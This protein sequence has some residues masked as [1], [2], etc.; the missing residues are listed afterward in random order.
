MGALA[1][2]GNYAQ[3][4]IIGGSTTVGDH[5]LAHVNAGEMILNQREQTRLWHMVNG[6]GIDSNKVNGNVSFKISGSDLVGVLNNYE[7][8]NRRVR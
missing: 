1:L 4:G 6:I 8:K 7:S 5:Q 3:G 2:M